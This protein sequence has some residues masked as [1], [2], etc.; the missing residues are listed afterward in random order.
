MLINEITEAVGY[1]A[2][3][4]K[5]VDLH[6]DILGVKFSEILY[7]PQTEIPWMIVMNAG[8]TQ[9]WIVPK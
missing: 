6:P 1:G 8:Y 3:V 2:N 9:L 4:V 7:N 5:T